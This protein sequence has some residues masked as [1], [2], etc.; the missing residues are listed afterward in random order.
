MQSVNS[1]RAKIPGDGSSKTLGSVLYGTAG[2]EPLASEAEWVDLVHGIASR[3]EAALKELYGRTHGIVFTLI[4]RIVKDP[5][6]AEEVALDV[7]LDVWR[8]AAT[9]DVARGTVVAWL[10]NQARSRAIDRLRCETRKKRTQA[11]EPAVVLEPVPASTQE[12]HNVLEQC[13]QRLTLD[14]RRAIETAY[15]QDLTYAEVAHR[16]GEPLGTIKTRIR[17]GLAK[18]RTLLASKERL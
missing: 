9:F 17:S 11:Y 13:L 3:S 15:F 5:L 16:L 8:K 18:L 1:P 6:T 12:Q 7:Y 4:F 14:E 2:A 10:M